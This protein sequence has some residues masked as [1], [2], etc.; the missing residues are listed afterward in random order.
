[1][2]FH[3]V[4]G[5]MKRS[6]KALLK[7]G[8]QGLPGLLQKV[9]ASPR[10]IWE[11]FQFHFQLKLKK[12]RK[13]NCFKPAQTYL[14][15]FYAANDQHVRRHISNKLKLINTPTLL[16][17]SLLQLYITLFFTVTRY[18]CTFSSG[19]QIQS[20]INSQNGDTFKKHDKEYIKVPVKTE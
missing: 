15:Y 9:Q 5:W 1:M 8:E 10:Q 16:I 19:A 11:P 12:R 3:F 14:W 18:V 17:Y 20:R 4:K 2:L 7:T 13:K 6:A